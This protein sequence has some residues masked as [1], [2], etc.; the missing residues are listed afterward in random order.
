MFQLHFSLFS[1][2]MFNTLNIKKLQISEIAENHAQK[3][4][5]MNTD[6]QILNR[7]STY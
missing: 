4:L 5:L 7:L 3:K 1:I 2:I 6:L